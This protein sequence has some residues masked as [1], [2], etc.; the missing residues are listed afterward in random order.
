MNAAMMAAL[1]DVSNSHFATAL[2]PTLQR[3]STS[4][5]SSVPRD[6]AETNR[7]SGLTAFPRW[8]VTAIN[9]RLSGEF[10]SMITTKYNAIYSPPAKGGWPEGPG[11]LARG[12]EPPRRYAPPLLSQGGE[13]LT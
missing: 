4:R 9:L 10:G 1:F 5:R 13:F 3:G 6:L 12:I 2:A 8:S 11:G 7:W